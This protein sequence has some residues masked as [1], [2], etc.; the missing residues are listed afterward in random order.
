[1]SLRAFIL[2]AL[3]LGLAATAAPAEESWIVSPALSESSKAASGQIELDRSP[4]YSD[5]EYRGIAIDSFPD[6][7]WYLREGADSVYDADPRDLLVLPRP[8][9]GLVFDLR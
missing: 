7:Q 4:F 3:F 6:E 8:A 2:P 1:M 5:I 9:P